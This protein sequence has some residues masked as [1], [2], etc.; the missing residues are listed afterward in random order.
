MGGYYYWWCKLYNPFINASGIWIVYTNFYIDN[1][2]VLCTAFK[3]ISDGICLVLCN[4]LHNEAWWVTF[5]QLSFTRKMVHCLNCELIFCDYFMQLVTW[6]TW[7]LQPWVASLAASGFLVNW[8]L[9]FESLLLTWFLS[10]ACTSSWLGLLPLPPVVLS[11]TVPWQS[12]N[13]PNKC[14]MPRTWCVLPTQGTVVTSLLL[15]CSGVKWAPRKS[16]SRWSMFKTKTL[17]TL[18]S[19]FQT[20]WSPV[21]VTFL[22]EV[23]PWH[24]PSSGTQHPSKKCSEEWVSN[25]Q[26]CLGERLSFT[27]TLV[28]GWMKW[29]SLKLRAIW[30]TSCLSTS[31]TRMPPPMRK[32]S[33]KMRKRE[34]WSIIF[35][36]VVYDAY[37]SV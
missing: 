25:S 11:S 35:E 20:M 18:W 13:L 30:M 17:P 21:F 27:G 1:V 28:K 15:P 32:A 22:P 23:S 4:W 24:P 33:M 10:L 37:L 26:L 31:S 19:G 2:F 12:Q 14:G 16:T 8:T 9:T 3:G 7:F 6:T 29:S 36:E 5:L 34:N